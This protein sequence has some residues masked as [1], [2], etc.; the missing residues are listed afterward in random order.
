M[1]SQKDIY[2]SAQLLIKQHGD[3]AEAVAEQRMHEMM[4]KDDA[5]GA[6]V[7]LSISCAIDDLRAT[8]QKGKLH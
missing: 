7:W 5:K 6:S 1:T 3:K 4:E 8:E 2:I